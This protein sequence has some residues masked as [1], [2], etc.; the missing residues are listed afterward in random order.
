MQEK[1]DEDKA[2]KPWLIILFV[3]VLDGESYLRSQRTIWQTI[4]VFK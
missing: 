3:G 2:S 1:H 4:Q